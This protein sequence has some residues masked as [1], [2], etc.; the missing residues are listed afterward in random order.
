MYSMDIIRGQK[1]IAERRPTQVVKLILSTFMNVH[2]LQ[3]VNYFVAK[4]EPPKFQ[5]NMNNIIL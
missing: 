3:K 2:L 1:T 4:T 5:N